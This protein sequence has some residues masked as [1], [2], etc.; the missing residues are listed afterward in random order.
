[1]SEAWQRRFSPEHIAQWRAAVMRGQRRLADIERRTTYPPNPDPDTI[2]LCEHYRIKYKQGRI[3]KALS[4]FVD[5]TAEELSDI[6]GVHRAIIKMEVHNTSRRTGMQIYV[7]SKQ[8][9]LPVVFRL[10][11]AID[12]D[13]VRSVMASSW[14]LDGTLKPQSC[15]RLTA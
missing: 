13:E 15:A 9:R 2:A 6:T 5:V 7:V 14:Q 12:R 4:Y 11:N 10:M 1:M 3:L 8:G